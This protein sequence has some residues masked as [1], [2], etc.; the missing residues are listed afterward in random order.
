MN[1]DEEGEACWLLVLTNSV[2]LSPRS[3]H[4]LTALLLPVLLAQPRLSTPTSAF[5]PFPLPGSTLCLPTTPTMTT[6]AMH[7]GLR[8]AFPTAVIHLPHPSI[9]HSSDQ[10]V[11]ITTFLD[12][13]TLNEHP[14]P[15]QPLFQS[16]QSQYLFKTSCTIRL[17]NIEDPVATGEATLRRRLVGPG[18]V[19][20]S[21]GTAR[22]P[23]EQD[24]SGPRRLP[25]ESPPCQS[26]EEGSIFEAAP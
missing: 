23:P 12:S 18:R 3:N 19:S 22:E 7:M 10:P 5:C 9:S 16:N 1:K 4:F 17:T 20:L 11:S 13:E 25:S 14:S 6:G 21:A 8:S 26:E 15:S 24:I 2:G